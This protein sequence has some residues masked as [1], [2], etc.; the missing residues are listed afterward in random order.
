MRKEEHLKDAFTENP[1]PI[2]NLI[3]SKVYNVMNELNNKG[4]YNSNS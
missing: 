4:D 3:T 1:A 2:D